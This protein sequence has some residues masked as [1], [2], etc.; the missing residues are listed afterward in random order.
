MVTGEFVVQWL[1][2]I[3]SIFWFGSVLFTD[4]VLMPGIAKMSPAAQMEFGVSVGSRVSRIMI[5]AGLLSIALGVVRGWLFGDIGSVDDLFGTTYGLAWLVAFIASVV[6]YA[7]GIFMITPAVEAIARETNPEA[8][9]A[10]IG[11]VKGLVLI[12]LLGFLVIFTT[13]IVMHYA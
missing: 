11:R 8:A 1:H 2:I 5:P 6:T 7:W 10:G 4:I 12:E 13:M 9:V 3:V